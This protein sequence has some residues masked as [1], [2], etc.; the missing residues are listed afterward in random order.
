MALSCSLFASGEHQTNQSDQ[1]RSTQWGSDQGFAAGRIQALAQT[2][3]GYLW[4][5]TV[6]GLFRFDG[7]RFVPILTEQKQSLR[8]VLGLTVD[9]QGVLWVRTADKRVRQVKR[10]SV[11]TLVLFEKK[12]L[13]ILSMSAAQTE[14]IYATDV[15]RSVV[16]LVRNH[17]EAL[18][19]HSKAVLIAISEATDGRLWI[20]TDRGLLSWVADSLKVE[21]GAEVDKETNCLLAVEDGHVWVGTDRGLA[22]WDGREL[23]PRLF[24]KAD[25]QHLQVLTL[26]EDRNKNLWIGTS[27]GLVRYTSSGSE[28]VSVR[29]DGEQ[30]AVTAL[31]QDREGDIWF[32]SGSTLERLESTAIVPTKP[33]YPASGTQFGPLYVDHLGRVWFANLQQGLYW[34]QDGI[35]HTV[36]RDGLADDEVYS[37]D[38]DG[39]DIWVGRRRNGLTRIRITHGNIESKTWTTQNGLAQNSVYVVRAA[40]G[41]AVWAGTLTAGVNRLQNG[42]FTHFSE[43]NGLPSN[44]ISAIET[45]AHGQVWIGTSAGVCKI[46]GARCVPLSSAQDAVGAELYSLLDDPL[47]G[48]WVGTSKGLSI[49]TKRGKRAIPIQSGSQPAILGLGS[50]RNG[51]LWMVSDHAVMSATPT[52][53]LGSQYS[54]VRTYGKEDGLQLTE[55]RRR[56]RSVVTDAHGQVWMTAANEVAVTGNEPGPFP[57][58]IPHVE[59]VTAD[60]VG[61]DRD[62]LRVP[63]GS[64]RLSVTFTGLDLHAP[65][66]VRFRYRLD[67]FDKSWSDVTFDRQASYTNLAPGNY[68]FRLITSNESN[69]W[70]SGESTIRIHVE[71]FIWQRWSVRSLLALVFAILMTSA[72]HIRT[73]TLLTQANVLADERLSERTR[74][75]R[76][77]H[78]TL[79][80][81]FISSLMHLH[82]AEKQIPGDSPFKGRL[83]FVLEGMEKVIEEARLAVVGLRTPDSGHESLESSLRD[84]FQEIG[85]IGN[86]VLTLGSSGRPRRLKPAA[87]EDISSIAKEAVLNALRHAGAKTVRV[88]VTWGWLRLSLQVSDDGSGMDAAILENGR[89][90][91]WGLASMRERAKQLEAQL[92]MESDAAS[93][94]TISLSVPAAVAYLRLSKSAKTGPSDAD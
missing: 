2:P 47:N 27:K 35:V 48:L 53:L 8:Q 91:H 86:A 12:A 25:M 41:G 36:S 93:G 20:G 77:V 61:L 17:V 31:M 29:S 15:D 56:S 10:D 59:D 89:P 83:T 81:G 94:T 42:H 85:D 46:D 65:S 5:G 22:Y 33:G 55:S 84:F 60:G 37:I 6:N 63:A 28:W 58:V 79:L 69:S 45:G 30:T 43:G 44:A 68:T 3:D 73:R 87:Y 88:T 80:Q 54:S 52:Q 7:F 62:N 16:R 23:T 92:N 50:D 38:G 9:R 39:D 11:S 14:G 26:M 18:P 71:P 67:D 66:K 24:A 72:Y 78:D 51:R 75:A 76:D 32:G 4:V 21:T 19:I 90:Q 64:K 70:N 40:P 1:Y 34:M 13:G 49:Y 74:I 82:A 57:V